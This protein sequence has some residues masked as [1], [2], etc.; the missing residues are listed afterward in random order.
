MTTLEPTPPVTPQTGP[1]A[2][3]S[4]TSSERLNPSRAA[5]GVARWRRAL[6]DAAGGDPGGALDEPRN[7]LTLLKIFGSTCRLADLCLKSP[8]AAATALIEGP[9][10]VIAEAARDLSN[11]QGGVGGPDALHGAL[12]P[13]KARVDLAIG[14]AELSGVWTAGEACV[15]RAEFAERLVDTALVWLL[16]GGINRGEL[17]IDL[18]EGAPKGVFALAGGDFAHEDLAPFGP[19]DVAIFYDNALFTGSAASMAERAFVRLGTEFREVFEGKTG[20][21][22][23]FS[24]RAPL[25]SGLQGAGLVENLARAQA[26]CENEQETKFRAFLASAR[27]VGGDRAAGGAFLEQAEEIIWGAE[28]SVEDL[29]TGPESA[30]PRSAFRRLADVL[31]LGLGR[32]RPVFRTIPAHSVF[33]KSSR[34]RDCPG[35]IVFAA[36][37]R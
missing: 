34:C 5:S 8:Q 25:G 21:Y 6:A 16:R 13:I 35:G 22:A 4:S 3:S 36:R 19:L 10:S 20:E 14:I 30:D 37:C 2:K 12:E 1:G 17:S 31:R 18:D 15:A 23:L 32:T 7:R 28:K 11:L 27:I 24:L 9:S 26:A 29:I 33:R